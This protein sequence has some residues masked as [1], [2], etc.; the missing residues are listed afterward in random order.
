MLHCIA[1]FQD[2]CMHVSTHAYKILKQQI[3]RSTCMLNI[4]WYRFSVFNVHQLKQLT[5]ARNPSKQKMLEFQHPPHKSFF[6][7]P[8]PLPQQCI[9]MQG[10]YIFS[11]NTNTCIQKSIRQDTFRASD[12]ASSGSRPS[13]KH[14]LRVLWYAE[15]CLDLRARFSSSDILGRVLLFLRGGTSFDWTLVGFLVP[16]FF[17]THLALALAFALAFALAVAL[18]FFWFDHPVL[19]QFFLVFYPVSSL[20]ASNHQQKPA[21]TFWQALAQSLPRPQKINLYACTQMP[22]SNT[23]TIWID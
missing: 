21:L 23:C 2:L 14:C 20:Q 12:F 11:S 9:L 19:H 18:A 6:T 4:S 13:N 15:L 7:A 10:T 5:V 8:V 16:D 22:L 1:K 17:S 3:T